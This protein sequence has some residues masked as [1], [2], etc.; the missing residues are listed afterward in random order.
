M[1]AGRESLGSTQKA[2]NNSVYE[3]AEKTVIAYIYNSCTERCLLKS[4]TSEINAKEKNC[5][6]HCYDSIMYQL[7]NKNE[8]MQKLA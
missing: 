6:S 5:L 3:D 1:S 4:T 7:K 2:K 8:T